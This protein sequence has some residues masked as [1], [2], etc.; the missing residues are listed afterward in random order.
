MES[1]SDKESENQRRM[2]KKI[3]LKKIIKKRGRGRGEGK[4]SRWLGGCVGKGGTG[5]SSDEACA[6]IGRYRYLW[7]SAYIACSSLW[8]PLNN[9]R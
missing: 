1:I 9:I 5:T 4:G 7:T 2:E 8:S 3:T 6:A